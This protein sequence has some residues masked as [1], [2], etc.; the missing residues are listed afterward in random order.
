MVT[1]RRVAMASLHV[2]SSLRNA[3]FDKSWT[4]CASHGP[5]RKPTRRGHDERRDA[6]EA[7]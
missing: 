2:L 5:A 6:E 1:V 4:P 3:A 7:D